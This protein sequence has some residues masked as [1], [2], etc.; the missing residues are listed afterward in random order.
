[1][2]IRGGFITREVDGEDGTRVILVVDCKLNVY[3]K[4]R[5]F[6]RYVNK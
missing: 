3:R 2:R 5:C 1:M 6:F 4:N